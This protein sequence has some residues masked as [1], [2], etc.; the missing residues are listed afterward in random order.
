MARCSVSAGFGVM[1]RSVLGASI[2]RRPPRP[3]TSVPIDIDDSHLAGASWQG[4]R[5]VGSVT[6][7]PQVLPSE[8]ITC[9]FIDIDG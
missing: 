1:K 8:P 5:S 4:A 9:F 6:T 7:V 3:G 2:A